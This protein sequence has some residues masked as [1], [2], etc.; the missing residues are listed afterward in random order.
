MVSPEDSYCTVLRSAEPG[1]VTN[2]H[3]GYYR[4][5]TAPAVAWNGILAMLPSPRLRLMFPDISPPSLRQVIMIQ[6][7]KS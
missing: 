2:A 7:V 4:N 5:R 3:Q 1:N 6:R